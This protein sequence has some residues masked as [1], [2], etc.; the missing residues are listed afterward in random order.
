MTADARS[1]TAL[2]IMLFLLALTSALAVSGVFLAR[3]A[4]VSVRAAE[5]ASS[6]EPLAERVLVDA[7][8]QWDTTQ[9]PL[10]M[11]GSTQRVGDAASPGVTATVWAT[12][13][14][15]NT[16]WLVAEARGGTRPQLRHRL[17]VLVWITNHVAK[18]VPGRAW[19][20][21]P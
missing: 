5:Q 20:Q 8:A 18:P 19:T 4:L 1:G 10:Q 13:L 9:R 15:A 7:V 12:R 11:V 17:G 14:D 21:L 3:N 2:P 6:V 16:Y